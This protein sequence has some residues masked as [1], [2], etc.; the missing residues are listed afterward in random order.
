VPSS[1]SLRN[2]LWGAIKVAKPDA[3]VPP[4]A[5]KS[6]EAYAKVMQPYMTGAR[7][8]QLRTVVEGLTKGKEFDTKRWLQGVAL[9]A[10]RAGFVLADSIEAAAQSLSR[11]GDDGSHVP[12]KDRIADLVAYSVSEPYLRLRKQ[13]GLTR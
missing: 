12:A 6:A 2:V 10:N 3:Q 1:A 4:D 5:A 7:L 13:V 11:E 8:D 9:T